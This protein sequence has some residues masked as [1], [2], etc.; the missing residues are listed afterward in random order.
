MAERSAGGVATSVGS[1]WTRPPLSSRTRP[2]AWLSVR[3]TTEEASTRPFRQTGVQGNSQRF[4]G[5]VSAK[6]YGE[7]LDPE[8]SNLIVVTAAAGIRPTRRS[9]VEVVY[10]E[11]LQH[12]R[13]NE[14]RDSGLDD[15][16]TGRSRH[17]GREID[18]VVG[19][20]ESRHVGLELVGGVFL[21]GRAF[22]T[23]TDAAWFFEG[24][25]EFKF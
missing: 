25:V 18:V 10:H 12:R 6:T 1:G 2:S 23:A 14:I 22:E 8:L 3:A 5:V 21:P 17:L 11:Y 16:P 24:T 15:D 9:S 13:S 4:G 20:K 7:L 19:V